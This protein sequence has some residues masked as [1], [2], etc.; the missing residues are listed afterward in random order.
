MESFVILLGEGANGKSVVLDILRA[1]LGRD[2]VSD[3]PLDAFGGEFRLSDT[4]GRLANIATE[5]QRMQRVQEGILK[6]LV[7][8]EP[9]QINRKFKQPV[10]M[11]PTAKLIFATNH[12]PPFAD[13]TDGLWRRMIVIPFFVQFAANQIDRHRARRIITSELAGV[14]NWSL[15]GAQRL[16]QNDTFTHCEVCETAKHGHRQDSD[17]FLQFMDECCQQGDG[18][19]VLCDD[20]YKAYRGFCEATGKMPKAKSEFG[21]QIAK[22]ENVTRRR[23]LS[24]RRRYYVYTG[25][26]LLPTV[27]G[28][29]Q[30]ESRL[31]QY[32]PPH[33]DDM[34]P[35]AGLRHAGEPAASRGTPPNALDRPPRGMNP[36]VS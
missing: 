9:V 33:R 8:G 17:P 25:I 31:R 1:M 30:C 22:L 10:T 4:I 12:L 7:S 19:S 29:P 26:D 16:I 18:L 23:E 24:D 20:L 5:M 35:R 15:A 34:F 14:L 13:T 36:G 27:L 11:Y 21:K 28:S 6:Q 3:V 32:Q 2:N